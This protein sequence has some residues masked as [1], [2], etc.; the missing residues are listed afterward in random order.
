MNDTTYSPLR[1]FC[2]FCDVPVD[3][4]TD[5]V[6]TCDLDCS[7]IVGMCHECHAFGWCE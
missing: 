7:G 3:P 5:A 4:K 2:Y 1:S 6:S